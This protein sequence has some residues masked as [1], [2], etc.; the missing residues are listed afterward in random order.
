MTSKASK[1]A[2][3]NKSKSSAVSKSALSAQSATSNKSK[4][5]ENTS[6]ASKASHQTG[7]S[8][9]IDILSGLAPEENQRGRLAQLQSDTRSPVP[10]RQGVSSPKKQL[11]SP[12]KAISGSVRNEST[13]PKKLIKKLPPSSPKDK[14]KEESVS[15]LNVDAP[16]TRAG[17][18]GAASATGTVAKAETGQKPKSRT[19]FINLF[20]SAARKQKKSYPKSVGEKLIEETEESVQE[21]VGSGSSSVDPAIDQPVDAAN[22]NATNPTTTNA[23]A[24]ASAVEAAASAWAFL[25]HSYAVGKASSLNAKSLFQAE[26]PD[27]AERDTD[28][29][30]PS[31]NEATKED[32]LHERSFKNIDSSAPQIPT[33][34][35][36]NSGSKARFLPE[37]SSEAMFSTGVESGNESQQKETR[38]NSSSHK[39]QPEDAALKATPEARE[40][41][42]G[43]EIIESDAI[44]S[45]ELAPKTRKVQTYTLAQAIACAACQ[46]DKQNMS[47]QNGPKL[48]LNKALADTDSSST[49]RS[50][51]TSENSTGTDSAT[52]EPGLAAEMP[53]DGKH[54]V[55]NPGTQ[56]QLPTGTNENT[57]YAACGSLGF[58]FNENPASLRAAPDRKGVRFSEDLEFVRVIPPDSVSVA[59]TLDSSPSVQSQE[60]ER[61]NG[62]EVFPRVTGPSSKKKGIFS[63]IRRDSRG[64]AKQ[65]TSRKSQQAIQEEEP[66]DMDDM[67]PD[68]GSD[69]AEVSNEERTAGSDDSVNPSPVRSKGD[70][71]SNTAMEAPGKGMHSRKHQRHTSPKATTKHSSKEKSNRKQAVPIGQRVPMKEGGGDGN[72]S[73]MPLPPPEEEGIE[74]IAR[75]TKTGKNAILIAKTGN[76]RFDIPTRHHNIVKSEYDSSLE[77]KRKIQRKSPKNIGKPKQKAPLRLRFFKSNNENDVSTVTLPRKGLKSRMPQHKPRNRRKGSSRVQHHNRNGS[78]STEA[79]EGDSASNSFIQDGFPNT[80]TNG[81][82]RL[83]PANHEIAQ[84]PLNAPLDRVNSETVLSP[85]GLRK[86]DHT[87]NLNQN[88]YTVASGHTDQAM[89]DASEATGF[90]HGAMSVTSFGSSTHLDQGTRYTQVSD[91]VSTTGGDWFSWLMPGIFAPIPR[92]KQAKQVDRSAGRFLTDDLSQETGSVIS[93]KIQDDQWREILDATETLAIRYKEQRAVGDDDASDRS[94]SEESIKEVN[95]AITKFREHAARLG[96]RERELM[97]AVRDDDRILHSGPRQDG[98]AARVENPRKQQTG[99][100]SRMGNAT[101]KFI[102]VFDFYFSQNDAMHSHKQ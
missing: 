46:D 71:V 12:K 87:D 17:Q 31:E 11:P 85:V 30:I 52:A 57:N 50:Q 6:I 9:G 26:A 51:S 13:S 82:P 84:H 14:S 32:S 39:N 36:A 62:G 38:M 19:K 77:G 3:S 1:S 41:G 7:S 42:N 5:S 21:T 102:D 8:D 95:D 92:P 18:P 61:A 37:V 68:E 2:T 44:V 74:L 20:K 63:W 15:A 25:N 28:G 80:H 54:P 90:G 78:L 94:I 65:L 91:G 83:S 22:D 49:R 59:E 4:L 56:K 33:E 76:P 73:S 45:N 97:A 67:E 88:S 101:D 86:Q 100:V 93:N 16:A 81:V 98:T 60:N 55:D 53:V 64:R 24:P 69:S 79:T 58:M 89:R 35:T 34:T 23:A 27:A 75:R 43:T 66:E 29:N 47:P 72:G 48:D 70:V 99:F 10:D 40:E 96:M